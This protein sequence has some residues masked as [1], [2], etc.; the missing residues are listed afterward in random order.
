MKIS[1]QKLRPTAGRLFLA[2]STRG[3]EEIQ[4]TG[5]GW[6]EHEGA[7]LLRRL[8]KQIEALDC[9]VRDLPPAENSHTP[10]RAAV[11]TS[12]GE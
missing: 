12:R 8:G 4:A 9:A 11:G 1:S 10:A 2:V 7:D 5:T 6:Q 3:V